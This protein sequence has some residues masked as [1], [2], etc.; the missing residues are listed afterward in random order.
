MASLFEPSLALISKLALDRQLVLV[1][2]DS[3]DL[4]IGAL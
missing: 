3:A 4:I 1:D 2:I